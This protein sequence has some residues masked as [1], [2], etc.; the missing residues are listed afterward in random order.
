MLVALGTQV[1]L[2]AAF[3]CTCDDIGDFRL[4]LV[5]ATTTQIV[6]AW[7]PVVGTTD[8]S[9]ERSTS[10]DFTGATA[11]AI[12]PTITAYGD[13]GQPPEDSCR[14]SPGLSGWL[15]PDAPRLAPATAYTYR[16]KA[17]SAGGE[18]I[19][20][21]VTA[22]LA[23]GPTRG[24]PGDLWADVVLG[25]PDFAQNAYLKTSANTLERP[26]GILIDKSGSNRPHRVYVADV[27]H[28]R[29]LGFDHL[30]TCAGQ[31]CTTDGDCGGG[32]CA[33]GDPNLLPSVVLGQDSFTDKSACNGDST[34]QVFPATCAARSMSLSR[35][36]RWRG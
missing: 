2:T 34:G 35:A 12:E 25:K 13:T 23:T 32:T 18:Q 7:Q 21:C 33:L 5:D 17:A 16:V 31:P 1:H 28:N 4:S 30:G 22:Q 29:V 6:M 26:S 3:V 8:Y 9:L 27:N 15:C 10:C 20:N 36:S 14:F 11:Y 19:S 24:V